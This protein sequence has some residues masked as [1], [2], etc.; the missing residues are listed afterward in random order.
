LF[1]AV[2][3][4]LKIKTME[5]EFEVQKL[6]N[7]RGNEHLVVITEPAIEDIVIG[8]VVIVPYAEGF[9]DPIKVRLQC[10]DNGIPKRVN[11]KFAIVNEY[12]YE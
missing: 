3:I 10:D 1:L 6:T 2:V 7:G 8:T 4:Y 12:I 5:K 9:K 11:K